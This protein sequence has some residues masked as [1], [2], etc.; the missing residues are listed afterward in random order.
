MN[1]IRPSFKWRF[2]GLT[3]P[4]IKVS[5]Q[6][7]KNDIMAS[8]ASGLV[9]DEE[10]DLF[11]KNG[12]GALVGF[13]PSNCNTIEELQRTRFSKYIQSDR[14][15]PGHPTL[16]ERIK[17]MTGPYRIFRN[18]VYYGYHRYI[19]EGAELVIGPGCSWYGDVSEKA[20]YCKNYLEMLEPRKNRGMSR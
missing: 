1:F 17:E 14:K 9:L 3:I 16:T 12:Y 15:V 10:N 19:E 11:I 7:N 4:D 6:E 8:I 13:C 5:D 2:V 18:D 20:V